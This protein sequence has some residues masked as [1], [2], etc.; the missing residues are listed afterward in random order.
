MRIIS[1]KLKGSTIYLPKDKNTR[2]LKDMVKESIFNVL[3]HSNKI[4]F[5]F[6]NSYILDLF[7]GTGSFGLECISRY[8][9]YVNF[10]EKDTNAI[11]ILNK[12]IE[13]FNIKDLTQIIKEDVFN[14]IEKN[15]FNQSKFDLIFCDPPFKNLKIN[16]LI[17]LIIDK[18]ILKESGVI[19]L[20]R[21]RLTNDK[22]P[23][24]FKVIEEKV[25]GLSKIIFG[26]LA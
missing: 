13:K 17:N 26:R 23:I 18:K 5:E 14:A 7:S 12:N 20:H 21:E 15:N 2:P 22:L 6:K 11:Q 3:T 16:E 24:Q 19:I 10:V 1:G 4:S 9:K 25:Y 8:S